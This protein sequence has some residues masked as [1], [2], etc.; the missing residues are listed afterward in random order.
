MK[1]KKPHLSSAISTKFPAGRSRIDMWPRKTLLP[2]RSHPSHLPF[3][4][5]ELLSL[6]AYIYYKPVDIFEDNNGRS[7]IAGGQLTQR[8][9]RDSQEA[10]EI[11]VSWDARCMAL[12]IRQIRDLSSFPG[13]ATSGGAATRK[14][15]PHGNYRLVQYRILVLPNVLLRLSFY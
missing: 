12:L 4:Y 10:K 15:L 2:N 8:N 7:R 3:G 6:L 14:Y 1:I 13:I 11:Q 9:V 5:F